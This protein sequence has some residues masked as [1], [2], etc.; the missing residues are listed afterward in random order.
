MHSVSR[1]VLLALGPLFFVCPLRAQTELASIFAPRVVADAP[2]AIP[3]EVSQPL[4]LRSRSLMSAAT[5]Q[6]LA[7]VSS[8]ETPAVIA[9]N[10]SD[11]AI[12]REALERAA[13]VMDP[14][15][16]S[17]APLRIIER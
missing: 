11:R 2:A 12:P 9:Y 14:Y 13:V 1:V 6:A 15:V 16:V 17:S 3:R 10:E 5:Q 7:N 8:F 4:S